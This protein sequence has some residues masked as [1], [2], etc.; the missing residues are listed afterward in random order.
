MTEPR[1]GVVLQGVDPPGEFCGMVEEI[2]S[3]GFSQLWLT[4]SSLHA[5]NCYAYLTL[6]AAA[7]L[8]VAARHRRDQPG[9]PPPRDHRGGRRDRGRDIRRPADPRYRRR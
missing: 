5:R 7:Q 2:E 9:H 4:D 3:L 6:A 8:A 1:S